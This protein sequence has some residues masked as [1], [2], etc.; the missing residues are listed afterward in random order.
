MKRGIWNFIGIVCV[1]I[2]FLYPQNLTCVW[3]KDSVGCEMEVVEAVRSESSFDEEKES[4]LLEQID[5]ATDENTLAEKVDDVTTK[6]EEIDTKKQRQI[7]VAL[8]DTGVDITNETLRGHIAE[9]YDISN[10]SDVN[11]HGTL[12]AEIIASN[13]N[14]NVKIV[15][16]RVFDENGKATVEAT[17]NAMLQAINEQVD[18]ISLSVSGY[19]TSHM[20]ISV[21]EK[22][23]ESG[24]YVVVAAGNEGDNADEFMPGNISDSITV[25]AVSVDE[26]GEKVLASYSNYGSVVD[27]SAMGTVVK[28]K[29]TEDVS[30]DE[31]YEG[32][33]VSAAN[34]SSYLATLLQYIKDDETTEKDE[35]LDALN[36]LVEDLGTAGR[37]DSFGIGYLSFD[38]INGFISDKSQ[39]NPDVSNINSGETESKEQIEGG[40]T[41]INCENEETQEVSENYENGETWENTET[42]VD[43]EVAESAEV[44]EDKE[45]KDGQQILKSTINADSWSDIE[46]QVNALNSA[47]SGTSKTI[48]LTQNVSV[49]SPIYLRKNTLTIDLNNYTLKYGGETFGDVALENVIHQFG[50]T[51]TVKNGTINGNNKCYNFAGNETYDEVGAIVDHTGG[52]MTL[53]NVTIKNAKNLTD[54]NSTDATG[55][56]GL[57]TF[58]GNLTISNCRFSSLS[59]TAIWGIHGS[60]SSSGTITI[61]DTTCD[62]IKGGFYHSGAEGAGSNTQKV[63]ISGCT[64]NTIYFGVYATNGASVS[65]SN[66]TIGSFGANC[67]VEKRGKMKIDNNST[68]GSLLSYSL[69]NNGE[70]NS[71][72]GTYVDYNAKVEDSTLNSGVLNGRNESDT[73]SFSSVLYICNTTIT[74]D[75]PIQ[76]LGKGSVY[77]RSGTFNGTTYGFYNKS[78]SMTRVSDCFDATFY[79]HSGSFVASSDIAI[80]NNSVATGY[81]NAGTFSGASY[82][83][84]NKGTIYKTNDGTTIK[85][86]LTATFNGTNSAAICQNAS[87]KTLSLNV[88]ANSSSGNAVGVKAG[89]IKITGGTYK[90]G[91]GKSAVYADDG[92]KLTITGGTITRYDAS[93]IPTNGIMANAGSSVSVSGATIK[94]INGDGI[95]NKTTNTNISNVTIL[96]C[97]TGVNNSQSNSTASKVSGNISATGNGINN[98][99]TITNLS[100]TITGEKIGVNNSGTISNLSA[101]VTG[102]KKGIRSEGSITQKS[103]TVT[104]T[105][106]IG[107]ENMGTYIQNSST[108]ISDRTISGIT[109]GVY[110]SGTFTQ[111]AGKITGSSA[112]NS[113]I[114]GGI[115]QNGIYHISGSAKVSTGDV[116][117]CTG[118]TINVSGVLS[119]TEKVASID[120]AEKNAG[121]VLVTVSYEKGALAKDICVGYCNDKRFQLSKNLDTA[122]TSFADT[123]EVSATYNG[124][125]EIHKAVLRAGKGG[126]RNSSKSMNSELMN[127]S[128]TNGE[129]GTIVL[130]CYLDVSYDVSKIE[131]LTGLTAKTYKDTGEITS[132]YHQNIWKEGFVPSDFEYSEY[133]NQTN[134][135]V[136]LLGEQ[137]LKETSYGSSHNLSD[138]LEEVIH[139][140]SVVDLL[141]AG[142]TY[143]GENDSP[144]QG[145]DSYIFLGWC[146][147]EDG[148]GL[149]YDTPTSFPIGNNYTWYP[150]FDVGY[151][152]EYNSNYASPNRS[153]LK[154]SLNYDTY[155]NGSR[156]EKITETIKTTDMGLLLEDTFFK[157][158]VKDTATNLYAA[159]TIPDNSGPNGTVSDYWNK[160]ICTTKIN[161]HTNEE[162]ESIY[163]Y[164]WIGW[165]LDKTSNF[166]DINSEKITE[167]VYGTGTDGFISP[168]VSYVYQHK[169]VNNE[170]RLARWAFMRDYPDLV[171]VRNDKDKSLL[172]VVMYAIWDEYPEIFAKDVTFMSGD[173]ALM[174]EET[175]KQT[176]IDNYVW[177]KDYE[178]IYK[179]DERL[180]VTVEQLDYDM[181]HSVGYG[182]GDMG[183]VSVTVKVEDEVGNQSYDICDVTVLSSAGV[184]SR[185]DGNN[186]P[187]YVRFVDETNWLKNEYW[188]I[189][190]DGGKKSLSD[191]AGSDE[192]QQKETME[193]ICRAYEIWLTQTG[194]CDEVRSLLRGVVDAD[195]IASLERLDTTKTNLERTM[196][197]YRTKGAMEPYSKWYL[198]PESVIHL[199]ESF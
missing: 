91:A 179:P 191:V 101:T 26:T 23:K 175:L 52:T 149:I 120:S 154:G 177:T 186:A 54:Y 87:G 41:S 44:C 9:G 4:C 30:D 176:I 78:T 115:Y 146:L 133:V 108:E 16:Y 21:I 180:L 184:S 107:I 95:E 132:V 35:V 12:M 128:F 165:S 159:G 88:S 94:D 116:Y 33:S 122:K 157:E 3:A 60:E 34:V 104:A 102:V 1:L 31:V 7:R 114:N 126:Q 5:E 46:S 121:R 112:N 75:K 156:L 182:G 43:E 144:G 71:Y 161:P 171:K 28:D 67:V 124:A 98:V 63:S 162:I 14:E 145:E 183:S 22:A 81:I 72:D 89:T 51:L 45:E 192:K 140:A 110:N 53:S 125:N 187:F 158:A 189:I 194:L 103:G 195:T 174:S 169:L 74:A 117:L 92:T 97:T 199:S 69:I 178:Q 15:P 25:S 190:F 118:K 106:G 96:N 70:S 136:K 10:M 148:S 198:H 113:G 105:D 99:G 109:W 76:N 37:D 163:R 170:E 143:Y 127:K 111:T 130:S 56:T 20:L 93:H 160:E 29:G 197:D 38:R 137:S 164:Q 155:G 42:A 64:L 141:V 2:G 49:K 153:Q 57:N 134:Y 80:Y 147:K 55:G 83:L 131:E 6:E 61:T 73:T 13:T 123:T 68:L 152:V 18:V 59:G 168:K 196:E 100:G 82:G 166:T 185:K 167:K 19:G 85:K 24:I 172:Y 119:G 8:I 79:I 66:S 50:G 90:G 36:S 48:K 173:E 188:N 40:E 150:I 135:Q 129:E 84:Y 139:G 77:V 11:G 17:C 151:S 62:N 181:L 142:Q 138:V 58:K 193:T 47:D 65:I 39:L 86:D 32:T 27:Y